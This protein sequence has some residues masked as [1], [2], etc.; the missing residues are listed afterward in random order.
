MGRHS[1]LASA[2]ILI[3]IGQAYLFWQDKL[4]SDPEKFYGKKITD[5]KVEGNIHVSDKEIGDMVQMRRGMIL[6][7]ALVN[8]DLRSLFA[9]GSF[10]YAKIEAREYEGGVALRIVLEERP[11]VNDIRFLGVSELN[12]QELRD[13]ITLKED[14]VY[15]EQKVGE[16]VNRII[17]KYREKGLFNAIVKVRKVNENKKQNTLD[18]IFAIDEGE[19]IK[20]SKINIL[21][22]KQLDPEEIM[23]VLELEEEGFFA[24]GTFKEDLFERDKEAIVEFYKSRGFLDAELEEAHWDIRWKNPRTQ[25]ERVIVIT[26]RV[27]EGEQYF[28]NGYDLEWDEKFLNP[29]TKKPLFTK[30]QIME[31]FEFTP[32]DVGEYFDYAKFTRD[33][34]I[35]NYLYSQQGYVFARVIPERTIIP[36]TEEAIAEK[37]NTE[38][39]RRYEA[40][41]RDYFN[42][43]KLEEILKKKP[44]LRGK[45]FVHNKFVI[46]EGDKGYIEFI[47]IKGN[48]KTKDKVI[49]RELLIKEGELFNAELV[50]R[51]RELVFNLGYFKEVNVDARPGSQEG[52][53]NLI[54]EVEEQPTGTISLGGGY[55]TQTGFSIFTEVSENN[56]NGTGQRLSGRV[57]FGPLRTAIEASWTEPWIFD[58]PWS[59]TLSG[60]Y[61][62]RQIPAPSIA[63]ASDNEQSTYDRDSVGFT[64]GV[65]HRFWV[66]WGHYHRFSPVFSIATNPSALVDDSVYLLINQ[67]WQIRNMLTNGIWYDNRDNIFNTTTGMRFDFSVDIVGSVIGGTDHYNR[68]NPMFSYYWWLFDY[69]FFNL[70]RK[71]VLRRWR[72][73]FEHRISLAFTQLTRPLYTRQ[74]RTE[75][76]YVEVE[77]RLYLGGYESLRGWTLFDIYYPT[78]WRQGG[79][80]RLLYGT[81]LRI[82]VEPSLFWLVL[83]WEAGALYHVYDEFVLDPE[84]TPEATKAIYRSTEL[85]R[86]NLS[87]DYFRYSWGFGFRLQIPILPLRIYL[88]KRLLWDNDRRWFREHPFQEGFEFVFGIGDRRF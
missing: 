85:N 18:V 9:S 11:K 36:L 1:R 87:M 46:A 48:K 16:S 20:I 7:P 64:I 70:I 2:I 39:Q 86:R 6:T 44:E 22:V 29:Y 66:N 55:G 8:G 13:A 24:D 5:I 30:E 75:N 58:T 80:H 25:E 43:R 49:R 79:S 82:P 42:L 67:G 52:K 26:Y 47:I 77:D 76:P 15:T 53:M 50:Q 65:G 3:V 45:K 84:N 21:G 28:Y 19:D 62:Y 88:A 56:L 71:N 73:V 40:Q 61:T 27:Y 37:K 59:L 74:D 83:F 35:I 60:F 4:Y 63:I 10:S 17:A 33:R 54:I 68:Y 23:S 38:I 12:E 72:V 51:S 14:E 81:E 32:G 69:T 41:G 57:E 78:S 34:G 31:F